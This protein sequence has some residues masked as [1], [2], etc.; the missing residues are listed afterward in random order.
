MLVSALV[1]PK[2]M[3]LWRDA[4]LYSYTKEQFSMLNSKEFLLRGVSEGC[5]ELVSSA[6]TDKSVNTSL[7][8]TFSVYPTNCPT[9]NPPLSAILVTF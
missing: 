2:I 5:C 4:T 1:P 9:K 7:S 6:D 8:E 3:C